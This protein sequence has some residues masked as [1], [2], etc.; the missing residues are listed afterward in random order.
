MA[1]VLTG[2]KDPRIQHAAAVGRLPELNPLTVF[3]LPL[4]YLVGLGFVFFFFPCRF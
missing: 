2:R 3:L 1:D 4:I